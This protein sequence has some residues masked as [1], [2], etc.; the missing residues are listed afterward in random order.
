MSDAAWQMYIGQK[1]ECSTRR[2]K[3]GQGEGA[4]RAGTI[5]E[6]GMQRCNGRVT[7]RK[8][9]LSGYKGQ[10][11]EKRDRILK[12]RVLCSPS[13][14][15]VCV[16]SDCWYTRSYTVYAYVYIAM[17]ITPSVY[18]PRGHAWHMY[19]SMCAHIVLF[20]RASL[21]KLCDVCVCFTVDYYLSLA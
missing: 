8:Q 10:G 18:L 3:K 1:R 17:D 13:V 15:V 4:T 19:V 21:Y 7:Y 9:A 2:W 11:G 16:P 5:T 20:P 6:P 12:V 14:W